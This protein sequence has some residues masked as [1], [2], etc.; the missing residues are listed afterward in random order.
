MAGFVIA[1]V[2]QVE[3]VNE[4]EDVLNVKSVDLV[5]RVKM[6]DEVGVVHDVRK[7]PSPYFPLMESLEYLYPD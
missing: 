4:V 1:Y 7:L 2:P 6:V 5:D 3:T